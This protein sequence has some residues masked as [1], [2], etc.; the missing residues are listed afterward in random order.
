MIQ[1]ISV[2][3]LVSRGL[4]ELVSDAVGLPVEC[5][6]IGED[7]ILMTWTVDTMDLGTTVLK[8]AEGLVRRY[9]HVHSQKPQLV[10]RDSFDELTGQG[11]Y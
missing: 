8:R 5:V 1:Q 6:V 7:N 3:L 11:R 4:V 9:A 10:T 2:G